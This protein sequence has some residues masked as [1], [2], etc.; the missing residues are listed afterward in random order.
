M[1]AIFPFAAPRGAARALLAVGLATALM[2]GAASLVRGDVVRAPAAGESLGSSSNLPVPRFVSLKAKEGNVRRGPSLENRID[3]IFTRKGMP[4]RVVAEYGHWRRVEDREGQG[5]W[6]H[7]AMLSGERTVII[8]NDMTPLRSAPQE[9]AAPRA[10]AEAEVIADL[11]ECTIDWCRV[12]VPGA[13][14]WLRKTAIWGVK[15]DEL[16]E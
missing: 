3:W 6:M 9:N 8:L 10:Y 12:E 7:Y 4:L 14:G 16:R 2:L 11:R 5:G 1:T 13:D 15:P